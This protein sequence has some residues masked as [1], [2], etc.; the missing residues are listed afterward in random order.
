MLQNL[1]N[2]LKESPH[3]HGK[4]QAIIKQVNSKP[5]IKLIKTLSDTRWPCRSDAIIAV[6]EKVSAITQALDE[7]EERSHNGHIG[8]VYHLAILLSG[9]A[10][11]PK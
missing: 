4:L 6:F 8:C 11:G 10:S 7:I 9:T 5:C 1:Y 2:F 3:R